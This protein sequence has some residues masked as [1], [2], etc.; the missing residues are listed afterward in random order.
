M[1][2]LKVTQNFTKKEAIGIVM[3]SSVF[4]IKILSVLSAISFSVLAI[5]F[6]ADMLLIDGGIAALSA[7]LS[8]TI[9]II[10][11]T[12]IYVF[13]LLLHA[14]IFVAFSHANEP[15][16]FG[17]HSITADEEKLTVEYSGGTR[18]VYLLETLTHQTDTK[19]YIVYKPDSHHTVPIRRTQETAEGLKMLAEAIKKRKFHEYRIEITKANNDP[20]NEKI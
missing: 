5:A 2:I 9:V 1:E 18:D 13:I 4:S 17:A 6:I 8:V 7:I 19:K 16:R 14:W 11:G 10:L 15:L 20:I 3:A 12:L